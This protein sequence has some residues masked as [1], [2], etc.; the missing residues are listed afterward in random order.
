MYCKCGCGKITSIAKRNRYNLGHVKGKYIEYLP[1]HKTKYF[2]KIGI[3]DNRGKKWKNSISKAT[4]GRTP[5]NKGKKWSYE[6]IKKLQG[7]RD[8]I[9]G[10]KNPNWRGGIDQKIRGL[11]RSRE[12]LHF[13]RF[14][15]NRDKICVF[16]ESNKKL[17][18]DHIKSFTYYPKL[19]YVPSNARLLCFECHKKTDNFGIKARRNIK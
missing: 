4:K 9:L 1:G 16:C 19:R 14:I 2:W 13:K 6:V 11:R 10:D 15:R 3:Y 5:W 18:V 12:Y 17:H 7:K 8:C